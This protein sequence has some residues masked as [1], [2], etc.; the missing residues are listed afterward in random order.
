MAHT[1]SRLCVLRLPQ[2]FL[3]AR[4][5]PEPLHPH[6]AAGSVSPC[7][8]IPGSPAR[9]R[10]RQRSASSPQHQPVAPC[11]KGKTPRP[12]R[13]TQPTP[14]GD[15]RKTQSAGAS[16]G[17]A[18]KNKPKQSGTWGDGTEMRLGAHS[19]AAATPGA[20]GFP[21]NT[22]LE[23]VPVSST[24]KNAPEGAGPA[25]PAAPLPSPP[26]DWPGHAPPA[27]PPLPLPFPLPLS[28]AGKPRPPHL[29]RSP[30]EE[31][32]VS[33]PVPGARPNSRVLP[34]PPRAERGAFRA[35]LLPLASPGR[36]S[37]GAANSGRSHGPGSAPPPPS[38]QLRSLRQVAR[39]LPGGSGVLVVLRAA[40]PGGARRRGMTA[41]ARGAPGGG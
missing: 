28:P 15:G 23:A 1:E 40:A 39:P 19:R 21:S 14:G 11:G 10:H 30:L 31:P 4:L 3:T 16:G 38:A 13:S 5:P 20:P 35:P 18:K 26:R 12:R 22:L 29:P 9:A 36:Q 7:A 27:I 6:R 41:E 8:S 25:V 34:R 24:A 32:V 33:H 17:W 2:F 37:P